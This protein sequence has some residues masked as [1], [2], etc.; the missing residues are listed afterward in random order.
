LKGFVWMHFKGAE[1][2]Q[3]GVMFRGKL[4]CKPF[5]N[6]SSP[7]L[8]LHCYSTS[9]PTP[10]PTSQNPSESYSTAP[11]PNDPPSAYKFSLVNPL[12]RLIMRSKLTEDAD[13]ARFLAKSGAMAA[14]GLASMT[15]LG[16]LGIDTAPLLTGIGITGFTLG[17]ALK[18][19]ATNFL[20]GVMLVF[21]KPFRKGQWLRVL[22]PAN[23]GQLEGEVQSID[24]RYV[25]LRT[26]E[27]G[28]VMVPSVIVYTN[29][30]LVTNIS[31]GTPSASIPTPPNK[32]ASPK[33]QSNPTA[34]K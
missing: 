28:L 34:D 21:G 9:T 29:P 22:S 5:K 11:M 1:M 18:E 20:S 10:T 7:F 24:A 31:S 13:L 23:Q 32:D 27:R 4:L 16:T 12:Y 25:L 2:F 19:I 3:K 6:T 17:F 33:S 30:I 14:Y 15:A 8:S 26:K